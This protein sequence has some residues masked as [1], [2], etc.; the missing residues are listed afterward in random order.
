MT[1]RR[2]YQGMVRHHHCQQTVDRAIVLT[3]TRIGILIGH[4][5]LPS[6]L[7]APAAAR[8]TRFQHPTLMQIAQQ[9]HQTKHGSIPAHNGPF[10][11]VLSKNITRPSQLLQGRL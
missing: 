11:A 7:N 5:T 1:T 6:P 3:L 2:H 4:S 9:P 10:P 8:T